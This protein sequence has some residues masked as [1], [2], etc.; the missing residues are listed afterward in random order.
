VAK[1]VIDDNQPGTKVFYWS[2]TGAITATV[3]DN[4]IVE[5]TIVEGLSE[6]DYQPGV[7]VLATW[8]ADSD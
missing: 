3:V 2:D 1:R 5:A 8:K 7:A 4:E 6:A